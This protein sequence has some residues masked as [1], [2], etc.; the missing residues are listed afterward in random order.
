MTAR[1]MKLIGDSSYN[2]GRGRGGRRIYPGDY[3]YN[4]E[5]DDELFQGAFSYTGEEYSSK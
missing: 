1:E 5:E 2:A 3:W 4:W